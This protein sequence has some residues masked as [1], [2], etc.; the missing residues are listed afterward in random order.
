MIKN[1]IH[2]WSFYEFEC[3]ENIVNEVLNLVQNLT[4]IS[5]GQIE[6]GVAAKIGYVDAGD[7]LVTSFYHEQLY[8]W[9]TACVNQVANQ[10]FTKEIR[11]AISDIWAVK[12][13][14]LETSEFHTHTL[15]LFS[16]IL[17]LSDCPKSHTIF[18]FEDNFFNLHYSFFGNCL[19]NY[20]LEYKSPCKKGRLI[21]FPSQIKHKI[22]PHKHR[23]T[24]Y[25]I[26]FNSFLSG[27]I[28]SYATKILNV[29]T[30][31][32]EKFTFPKP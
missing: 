22:S 8:S 10:H 27:K 23:D 26:S 9:L 5:A 31:T 15:S 3:D 20:K 29:Q 7:N 24:R 18:N 4:Y 21:I 17:Y 32:P 11:L 19:K 16:G 12:T 2:G 1:D 28:S 30:L 25:T 13:N 14:F 6:H